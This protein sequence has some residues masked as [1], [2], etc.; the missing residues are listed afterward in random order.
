MIDI[1]RDDGDNTNDFVKTKSKTY[2]SRIYIAGDINAAKQ[3]CRE[4]TNDM[5]LCVTVK[6][7]TYIYSGGCEEG[8]EIGLL[9]YPRFEKS[10][11]R[12]KEA[13]SKL[14]DLLMLE[15]HQKT[16]LTVDHSD[17]V[18]ITRKLKGERDDGVL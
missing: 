15:L 6:P 1:V 13:T 5:G 7:S 18:L 17:T 12:V 9:V 11:E 4:L 16:C 8:L 2:W 14:A 3:T 10:V